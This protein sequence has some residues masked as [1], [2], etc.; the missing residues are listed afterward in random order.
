MNQHWC[1]CTTLKLVARDGKSTCSICGGK[2]AYGGSTERGEQFRK[3]LAGNQGATANVPPTTQGRL[4]DS[5]QIFAFVRW[6]ASLS[7]TE[8]AAHEQLVCVIE[9]AQKLLPC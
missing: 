9:K 6:V 8:Y 3:V 7:K 2:D 5:T 4:E 1:M